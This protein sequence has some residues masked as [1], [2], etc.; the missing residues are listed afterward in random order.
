MQEYLHVKRFVLQTRAVRRRRRQPH[1]GVAVA[2]FSWHVHVMLYTSCMLLDFCNA[3]YNE[4]W[5]LAKAVKTMRAC[6]AIAFDTQMKHGSVK[7]KVF[8]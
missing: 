6:F 2:P 5:T 1:V 7:E 8:S 3:V 4:A